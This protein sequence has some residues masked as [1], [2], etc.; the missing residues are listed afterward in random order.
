VVA[1]GRVNLLVHPRVT[2]VALIV[3]AGAIATLAGSV[4][5]AFFTLN[6]ALHV[7]GAPAPLFIGIVA[8]VS[9]AVATISLGIAAAGRS[10]VS[11]I[12]NPQQPPAPP[13]GK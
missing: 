1:G 9:T 5:G 13:A 10:I 12:D 8:A 11:F 2:M 4:A 3:G 7:L 6:T